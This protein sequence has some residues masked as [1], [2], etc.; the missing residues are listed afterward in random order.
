M[1]LTLIKSYNEPS[2]VV[3]SSEVYQ[4]F[5]RPQRRVLY[6]NFIES[7]SSLQEIYKTF[8][9]RS[10]CFRSCLEKDLV[11]LEAE[12]RTQSDFSILSTYSLRDKSLYIY[13]F[14]AKMLTESSLPINDDDH[15]IVIPKLTVHEVTSFVD[16]HLSGLQPIII[17]DEYTKKY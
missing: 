17:I 4:S 3:P 6:F 11:N 1:S 10:K 14:I 9:P 15:E 13:G 16:A 5:M 8:L 7:E 2:A 12:T